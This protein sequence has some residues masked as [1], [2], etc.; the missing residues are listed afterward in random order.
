MCTYSMVMDHFEPMIPKVWPFSVPPAPSDESVKALEKM[1]EDFRKATEAAKT[2][3][4]LTNQPDC[5]DP[6][7][8]PLL[9]R[10][11]ELEK[12]LAELELAVGVKS[13]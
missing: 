10:V 3:D 12:R 7:K 11:A 2:V 1:F 9:D 8:L 6:K 5:E 4:A 13:K